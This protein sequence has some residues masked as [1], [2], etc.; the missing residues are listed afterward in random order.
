[1]KSTQTCCGVGSLILIIHA[2]TAGIGLI[3]DAGME[4]RGI[5]RC[6]G[7]QRLFDGLRELSMLQTSNL[8]LSLGVV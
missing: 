8:L 5:M 2:K 1:M 6:S 7:N 4:N 3:Y